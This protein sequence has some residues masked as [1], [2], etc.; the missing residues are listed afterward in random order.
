MALLSDPYVLIATVSL[1]IQVIVLFMLMYGYS[2]KSKSK[3][4]Q[5]GRI[6]AVALIL[7]LIMIFVI[8]I[9]SFVYALVPSYIIRFP[10]EL[11][12]I[13]GL[14][15]GIAGIVVMI[16]GSW[17]VAT[18]HFSKE[19]TGCFKRKSIMRVTIAAW[20]SALIL[21]IVLYI[22]FYGAVLVS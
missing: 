20:F 13:V 18:W 8:M 17:L 15:H 14:F 16:L 2:L 9:P 11:I 22:L 10:L 12:S 5:H 21:G 4:W 6:M 19:V 7:H 3:F 1:I